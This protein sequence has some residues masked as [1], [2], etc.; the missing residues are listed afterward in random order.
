MCDH[1]PSLEGEKCR[2]LHIRCRDI[3]NG[4]S[5]FGKNQSGLAQNGQYHTKLKYYYS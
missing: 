3:L 4:V 2:E 1:S 5:F